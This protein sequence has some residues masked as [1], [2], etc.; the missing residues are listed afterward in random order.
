MTT[1][2]QATPAQTGGG[3]C[4]SRSDIVSF[5]RLA[6]S[7]RAYALHSCRVAHKAG[8]SIP[9]EVRSSLRDTFWV[10]WGCAEVQKGSDE[11]GVAMGL[12]LGGSRS[13]REAV[14]ARAGA[15]GT[16]LELSDATAVRLCRDGF[17]LRLAWSAL[18][19]SCSMLLRQRLMTFALGLRYVRVRTLWASSRAV[20]EQIGQHCTVYQAPACDRVCLF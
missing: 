3:T 4:P 15:P 20:S 16:Q 19:R 10:F 1:E 14:E 5:G 6:Q 12:M 18:L 8:G 9:P 2:E 17:R 7:V 13:M 11:V